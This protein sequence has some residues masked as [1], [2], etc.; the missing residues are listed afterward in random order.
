MRFV[1]Y[2]MCVRVIVYLLCIYVC[3]CLSLCGPTGSG[4]MKI[5]VLCMLISG[6]TNMLEV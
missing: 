6:Q 1:W 2:L 4:T 3:F 5:P